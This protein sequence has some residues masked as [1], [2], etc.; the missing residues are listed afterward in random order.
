MAEIF[1]GL[2]EGFGRVP[3]TLLKLAK[4]RHELLV[5][6]CRLELASVLPELLHRLINLF[7]EVLDDLLFEVESNVNAVERLD[8]FLEFLFELF[9][10]TRVF[11]GELTEDVVVFLVELLQLFAELWQALHVA[12]ARFDFLVENHTVEALLALVE[13]V[14]E[15][16][17]GFGDE[18]EEVEVACDLDFSVLDAFGNFHFLFAGQ[19]R[20]LAH[21]LEVHTDRVVEDVEFLVCLQ[22]FLFAAIVVAFLVLEAVDFRGVDDVELHVAQAL[23]DRLDI[24]RIDEIVR[25]DFVDVVVGQVFLFLGEFDQFADFFLN[26]RRID[27]AFF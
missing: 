2:F 21:L 4:F 13:F 6:G 9:L 24:V 11:G 27:A 25:E 17:I 15:V 19:E 1:V 12:F 8:V 10:A 3:R 5:V 20:D 14:G 22:F 26:F 7:A 18:S 16:E 23:H